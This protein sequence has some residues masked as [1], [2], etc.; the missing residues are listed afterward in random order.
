LVLDAQN[1][2]R[3]ANAFHKVQLVQQLL[4][5]VGSSD[6]VIIYPDP[7]RIPAVYRVAFAPTQELIARFDL[8]L[9]GYP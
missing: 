4:R 7:E 6:V 3:F 8:R 5:E 2:F 1:A 9:F